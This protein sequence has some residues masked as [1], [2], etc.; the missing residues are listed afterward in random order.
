MLIL[1]ISKIIG[2]FL[3]FLFILNKINVICNVYITNYA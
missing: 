3:I 2:I 1:D